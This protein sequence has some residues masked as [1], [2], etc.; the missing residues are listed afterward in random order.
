MNNRVGFTPALKH[1]YSNMT[2]PLSARHHARQD[3]VSC[4]I[5]GALEIAAAE[6]TAAMEMSEVESIV[7]LRR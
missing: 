3:A 6:T 4:R 7:A 2:S 5:R 1:E